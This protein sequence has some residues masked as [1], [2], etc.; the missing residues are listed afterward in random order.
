MNHFK[1]EAYV[2]DSGRCRFDEWYQSL[3]DNRARVAVQRRI[4]RLEAGNFGDSKSLGAGLFELRI[5]F[6][7]GYRI[8]FT[9]QGR[10]IILLLV[11]GDKST[12]RK[13]IIAARVLLNC[14]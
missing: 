10:D 14:L 5:A 4:A 1:V 7:A 3:R 13:D 2:D 8:Y 6:G 11:G 9:M 12:Q